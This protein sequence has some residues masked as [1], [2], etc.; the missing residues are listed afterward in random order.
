MDVPLTQIH[1]LLLE[2]FVLHA[3][4]AQPLQHHALV[5]TELHVRVCM[6]EE[7]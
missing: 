7:P 5:L 6:K 3:E 1:S 4:M 2:F